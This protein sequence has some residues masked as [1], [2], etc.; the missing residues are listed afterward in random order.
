MTEMVKPTAFERFIGMR[1]NLNVFGVWCGT[2]HYTPDGHR[3]SDAATDVASS[4]DESDEE[5]V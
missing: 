5:T 2:G 4:D 3:D 1:I